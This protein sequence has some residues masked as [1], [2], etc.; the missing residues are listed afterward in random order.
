MKTPKEILLEQSSS[1]VT[2]VQDKVQDLYP[3]INDDYKIKNE[4]MFRN[5]VS[6]GNIGYFG[7]ELPNPPSSL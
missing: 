3:H 2:Y 6:R 7:F 4:Q 1:Y 5:S